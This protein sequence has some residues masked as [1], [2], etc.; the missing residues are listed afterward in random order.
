MSSRHTRKF[1]WPHSVGVDSDHIVYSAKPALLCAQAV[2]AMRRSSH[3]TGKFG[4]A[5]SGGA[6]G[7]HTIYIGADIQR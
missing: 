6:N 4:W 2:P 7:Y 5:H 3:H 1:G